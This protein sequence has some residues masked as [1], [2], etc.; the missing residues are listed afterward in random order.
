VRP[1]TVAFRGLHF[2]RYG[3]DEAVPSAVFLG[4]PS[5]VRGYSYGSVSDGCVNELNSA[6]KVG[7]DCE[8][9]QQL[10]GSRIAVGNVELRLPL[11]RN[12]VRGSVQLPPVEAIAF[13]DAG[14]AWGKIQQNDGSFTTTHLNFSRGLQSDADQ[15][16][17]LTSGGLG[18][19]MNLFGYVI[20]EADYVRAFER[21]KSQW[22]FSFQ[23]GF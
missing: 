9:Y 17:F 19:R 16:G 22:Q 4:Y 13:L 1:L 10:F 12:T 6:T 21:E 5:L 15:R 3:R 14:A 8:V 23:P 20:V 2:G 11:I 18:A 7:R